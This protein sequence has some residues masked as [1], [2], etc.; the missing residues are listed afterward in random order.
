M[1][2]MMSPFITSLTSETMEPPI[3]QNELKLFPVYLHHWLHNMWK[4]SRSDKSTA[5]HFPPHIW[6]NPISRIRYKRVGTF[7]S[8]PS[9]KTLISPIEFISYTPIAFKLYWCSFMD[10]RLMMDC[11]NIFILSSFWSIVGIILSSLWILCSIRIIIV[12]TR[13]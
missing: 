8:L 3:H 9:T 7:Y 1:L 4:I 10:V 6:E 11:S 13:S 12:F 5:I 2:P